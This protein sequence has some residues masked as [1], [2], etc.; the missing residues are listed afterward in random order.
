MNRKIVYIAGGGPGNRYDVTLRVIN[1]LKIADVV[2][3]D[4]LIDDSLLD[5]CKINCEKIYVGKR[6]GKHSLKQSEI[7][8]LLIQKALSNDIVLRLKGG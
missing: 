7:D 2:L 1:A 6:S 4:D 8:S 5:Y 3:Y